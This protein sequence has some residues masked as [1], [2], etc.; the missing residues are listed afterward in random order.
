MFGFSLVLAALQACYL[1]QI[2]NAGIGGVP[3]MHVFST[4]VLPVQKQLESTRT[5]TRLLN[6]SQMG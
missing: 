5:A 3:Q 6:E 1:G 2:P 4:G